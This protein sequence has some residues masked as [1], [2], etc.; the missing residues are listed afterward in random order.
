M[1]LKARFEQHVGQTPV[2]ELSGPLAG[3]I[4]FLKKKMGS[5]TASFYFRLLSLKFV[6]VRRLGRESTP[7]SKV[8]VS[9]SL[10]GKLSNDT[11][12]GGF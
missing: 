9:Q 3:H 12:M 2:P 6:Y 11:L 10:G 5:F 8:P 1:L 7:T 4:F